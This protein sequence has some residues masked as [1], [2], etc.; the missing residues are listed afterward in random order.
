MDQ[1]RNRRD[2]RERD[3]EVFKLKIDISN[4]NG[5]L[6]I[7]G[8]MDWITE[9]DKFYEYM[10]VSNE[11]MVKYVAYKLKYAASTW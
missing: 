8:F 2:G 6:D 3:P 7:E 10:N 4:F 9:C 11:K 5:E 1:G